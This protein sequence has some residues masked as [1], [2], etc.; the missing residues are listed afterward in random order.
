ME[1]L[2]EQAHE[3]EKLE[4]KEASG[5]ALYYEGKMTA[6]NHVWRYL[7]ESKTDEEIQ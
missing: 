3:A 7:N 6:Y 1:W 2:Q 5:W 4:E